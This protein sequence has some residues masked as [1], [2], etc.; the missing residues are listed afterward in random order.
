MMMVLKVVTALGGYRVQLVVGKIAETTARG[1]K[2]VV[3]IVV[4][5]IHSIYPEHG[6]QTPFVKGLVVRNKGQP[7]YQGN[8]LGPYFR[9]NGR[10]VGVGM[11]QTMNTRAPVGVVVGLWLDEGVETVYYLAATHHY[12]AHRAYTAA[13]GI[14]SLEIYR[15]K[16]LHGVGVL[17]VCFIN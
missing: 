7:F 2:G 4:G 6:F 12:Y 10:L 15:R 17:K 16:V 9:K 1:P 3:K 8:Y 11:R 13:L 5:V 14:G